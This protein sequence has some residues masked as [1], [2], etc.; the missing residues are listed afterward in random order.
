MLSARIIITVMICAESRKCQETL[1][2]VLIQRRIPHLRGLRQH[3][4]RESQQKLRSQV[5][6]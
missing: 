1:C 2:S 5:R 4:E 3:E 6:G